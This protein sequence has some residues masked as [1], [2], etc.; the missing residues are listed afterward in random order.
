MAPCPQQ[1]PQPL[2]TE[3]ESRRLFQPRQR[4]QNP[5]PDRRCDPALETLPDSSRGGIRVQDKSRRE[6]LPAPGQ[7]QSGLIP[8]PIIRQCLLFGT[9]P[10]EQEKI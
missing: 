4:M 5:P 8:M 9:P 7:S 3:Q 1:H 10:Q 6:N 2:G